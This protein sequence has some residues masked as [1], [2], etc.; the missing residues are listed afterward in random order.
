MT[1]SDIIDRLGG[2]CAVA[3]IFDI[4]P[5]AVTAWRREGIPKAR[6]MYLKLAFPEAFEDRRSSKRKTAVQQKTA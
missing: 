6:E 4:F 2:T 5:Q 1:P 3:K